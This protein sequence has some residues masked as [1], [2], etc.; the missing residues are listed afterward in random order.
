MKAIGSQIRHKAILGQLETS[1]D[2]LSSVISPR[3]VICR[4]GNGGIRFREPVCCGPDMASVAA[5]VLRSKGLL[6]GN[7]SESRMLV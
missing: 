1:L 4:V 7:C 2:G 6:V 5:S 3:I